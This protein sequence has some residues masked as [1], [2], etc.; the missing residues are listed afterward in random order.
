MINFILIVG[1]P[2]SGKTYL[3][4]KMYKKILHEGKKKIYLYDD[5]CIG[6]KFQELK[7]H[8]PRENS[9]IIITDPYFCQ[10][11]TRSECVRSLN[12]MFGE[13]G[14]KWIFFENNKEKCLNNVK[15]RTG[16]HRKVDNFIEMLSRNYEIDPSCSPLEIWQ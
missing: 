16:E 10:K 7:K 2:G 14:I 12:R 1:L 3:A 15:S 11:E 5:I 13:V 9:T 8:A 6:G 4:K